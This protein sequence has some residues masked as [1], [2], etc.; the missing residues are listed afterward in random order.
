[1]YCTYSCGFEIFAS[2]D[3]IHPNAYIQAPLAEN[4][5]TIL[6]K[7]FGPYD[8]NPAVVVRDLYGHKSSGASFCNHLVDCMNHMDYMPCP[9]Y[10]DS[11]MKP[12]VIMTDGA[13]YYVYI[14]LYV[15]DILFIHH[16]AKSVTTKVDKYFKLKLDSIGEP[17]MYLG[18]KVRPMKLDND[19]WAWTLSPS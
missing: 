8:G 5:W 3:S 6:G 4:I 13:E 2:E 7:E 16:D 1:M 12:M 15:D 9:T 14:L 17:D 10:P 19:V 18:A 11:W